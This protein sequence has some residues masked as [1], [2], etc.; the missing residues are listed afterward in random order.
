MKKFF[1]TMLGAF[2]GT[3]LAFLIFGIV[4]FVSGIVMMASMTFSSLKMP[5]ASVS[6]NSV[7]VLNLSGSI[8]ERS[9]KANFQDL[10]EEDYSVPD[11][12]KDILSAISI[13]KYD[14]RISG[15]VVKCNGAG[16]GFATAK[17]I[18]DA[19]SDFRN[20][21]KWIYA[22][23]ES[24]AQGDY[25]IASLADSIYMNPVGMLDLHGVVSGIPFFKNTLEKIGV[26]MQII[27]V[28]TFKSAVEPYMLTEMSEANRLQTQTYIS[29][30]WNNLT[31]SIAVSRKIRKEVINQ[32]ADSL[33]MFSPANEVVKK[34]FV[35]G[36][37]YVHE[38]ESKVRM[39]L[40]LSEDTEIPA[41]TVSEL[42]TTASNTESSNKIA[43]VYANGA[44]V[45]SGD[46][47]GINSSELV[48]EILDLAKDDEIKGLVLRVNSP[49]G[50]AYASEQIWEALEQFKKTG[51]P[52]AVS[53]GDYA[54][55]GGYYISCGADR[56]FAEPTTLTGSIGI[57]AM[58]PCMSGLLTD[59][60]GVN[61]DFVKTNAN[62]DISTV[63]PLT[64]F[65][66]ASFQKNVNAGYELFTSRCAV[67][68]KMNIN[69][70]KSIAEGR[71]WD[72]MEAK[73]IGL[74]DEFGN[75]TDAVN[76]V[77]T[78]AGII[79]DYSVSDYPKT[80][81]DFLDLLFSSMSESYYKMNMQERF[82]NFYPLIEQVENMLKQ[83]ELQCRMEYIEFK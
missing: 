62:T 31:D 33:G 71:V 76:W 5:V 9:Q 36:L 42:L 12:L 66:K 63:K 54:A 65:Q 68:R 26:E 28:G 19:L 17:T 60:L 8:P 21:G 75:V 41:V 61:F 22:Y 50:S 39:A 43:V 2:V 77:A 27:R 78:Q 45:V 24:L 4:I 59:K 52:F 46:K 83:D 82:G 7:L 10:L 70:L 37:C 38:F 44:I 3:W 32:F 67:G 1:S 35:D 25:Y 16:A 51:K 20:S 64:E 6:D 73:K 40:G 29:N 15:I 74:V 69:K 11:N 81:E 48:P 55:S 80:K 57:Y 30:L 49:G 23:G 58:V 13:A 72:G 56:I 34:G 47:N 53:M 79:G 14:S 18:R